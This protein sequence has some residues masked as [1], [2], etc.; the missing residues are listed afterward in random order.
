[1]TTLVL[2]HRRIV[3]SSP[4][5]AVRTCWGRVVSVLDT[6]VITG[7]TATF[8]LLGATLYIVALLMS[9]DLGVRMREI[10]AAETREG[11][12]LKRMEVAEYQRE[13]S[14]GERH[15]TA[16]SAMEEITVLRYLSPHD[17]SLTEAHHDTSH[18]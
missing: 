16:L 17:T 6:P 8:I 9:F 3:T 11:A 14:F 7:A 2:A 13:A 15:S 5:A 1:M 4:A 12:T 18:Q 10:S